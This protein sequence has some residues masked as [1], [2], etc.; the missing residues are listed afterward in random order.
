MPQNK[1]T[2]IDELITFIENERDM[3]GPFSTSSVAEN[4]KA[5]E[6]RDESGVSQTSDSKAEESETIDKGHIE[7]TAA[8]ESDT[9]TV[10]PEGTGFD[11]GDTSDSETMTLE[12][13][14]SGCSTL[15]ELRDLCETA[16]DLHTDLENT[17]LVFG[18]GNP[19]ADL[20][21]VGEAPGFNEDQQGEPF[22]G[23]A[24]QLLN[25][26]LKA[27]QFDREDVYIAN[28]LKH[29]PP[30]NRNPTTEERERSLPY[31]KRQIDL[32]SPKVILCVGKVSGTTL[33]GKD[34]ALK[35]MRGQFYDYRGAKLTVTYHPAALL[36]NPKWKRP[37]WED[38]QKV[39]K[40]YDELNGSP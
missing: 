19:S 40:K 8:S 25:K 27:I 12:E 32:I 16:S 39:R 18:V 3:Y 21:I 28:I 36:R 35:R 14:L 4:K 7:E 5:H 29:R 23:A 30:D 1:Q 34:D 15:E 31:L 2:I 9:R 13:Q 37:V 38:V 17:N 20:M 22:V 24:G 11:F 26:I 6:V 10:Q 33:L